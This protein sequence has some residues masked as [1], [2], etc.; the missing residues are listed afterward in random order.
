[1]VGW[2]AYAATPGWQTT[3][4]DA[5]FEGQRDAA[6]TLGTDAKLSIIRT[7]FANA[8]HGI[9]VDLP[10]QWQHLYVQDSIFEDISEAV[11]TLN[12]PETFPAEDEA[13]LIQ[14]QNQLNLLNT[15]VAD[16]GALVRFTPSGRSWL[17]PGRSYLV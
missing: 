10:N 9:R 16:A 4:L 1:E 6:I 15:G 3:L 14:A 8:P 11:V 17:G 13:E 12:D 2:Q 7:R 5:S